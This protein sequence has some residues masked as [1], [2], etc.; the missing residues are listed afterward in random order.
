MRRAKHD[1]SK[2]V[3]L[4][5]SCITAGKG[6]SCRGFMPVAVMWRKSDPLDMEIFPYYI[7][8]QAGIGRTLNQ[9]SNHRSASSRSV[10]N[11]ISKGNAEAS[12]LYN[13]N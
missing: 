1:Q 11:S 5:V 9:L 7:H 13:T 8:P 3:V 12:I 10:N 2:D 4:A 6:R